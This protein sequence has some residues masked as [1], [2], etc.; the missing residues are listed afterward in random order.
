M[1]AI[2]RAH[3]ALSVYHTLLVSNPSGAVGV[4]CGI[5]RI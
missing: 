2:S 3:D 5:L 1:E 4:D